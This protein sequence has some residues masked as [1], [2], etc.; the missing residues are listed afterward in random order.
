MAAVEVGIVYYSWVH[1]PSKSVFGVWIGSFTICGL[2]TGSQ[3]KCTDRPLTD[4]AEHWDYSSIM[5]ESRTREQIRTLTQL[6]QQHGIYTRPTGER[7]VKQ[8]RTNARSIQASEH[9]SRKYT[10]FKYC[11]PPSV[12]MSDTADTHSICLPLSLLLCLITL[13]IDF[14]KYWGSWYPHHQT[15][16]SKNL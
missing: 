3:R 12:C 16:Q 10:S 13:A 1:I 8:N 4:S 11:C 14:T 15:F 5:A 2:P 7:H 6:Q 9:S